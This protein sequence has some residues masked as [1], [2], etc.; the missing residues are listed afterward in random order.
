MSIT[1]LVFATLLQIID[2]MDD[3]VGIPIKVVVK[4]AMNAVTTLTVTPEEANPDM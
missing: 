1:Y 4:R 3:K 2:L